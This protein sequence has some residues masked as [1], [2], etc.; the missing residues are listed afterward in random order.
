M[1]HFSENSTACFGH[2]SAKSYFCGVKFAL[3]E[4]SLHVNV[5]KIT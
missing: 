2:I 3:T 5:F 4:C 1:E